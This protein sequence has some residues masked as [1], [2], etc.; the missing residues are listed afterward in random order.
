MSFAVYDQKP[1]L[2]RYRN[3]TPTVITP[4]YASVL[5]S[6]SALVAHTP[7][8]VAIRYFDGTLSYRELDNAASALATTLLGKGFVRGDRLGLFMQNNPAFIIGLL[9]AW[10]LGGTAVTINPMNKAAELRYIFSDSGA[11]ALLCLD[12]LYADAVAPAI[13]QSNGMPGIVVTFSARDGQSMNDARVLGSEP[14][15]PAP[16]GVLDLQEIIRPGEGASAQNAALPSAYPEAG[17]VAL[18]TYTSGTTGKPK[19]AMNTHGNLVFNACV[20]RDWTGLQAGEGNI[21]MAPVFHITGMVAHAATS[22]L[23]GSPLILNHRFHPEVFLEA[24]RRERPIFTIGAITAF[25]SLMNT[26]MIRPGDFDSFRAIYSGGAP[27]SPAIADAFEALTGHYIHNAYGMT[28]TASATLIV[29]QGSRA[30]VD[31]S[32]GALSIGVP[33]FN[34]VIRVVREDGS[35]TQPNEV[36]ELMACGPQLMKGYWN[37]PKETA[38]AVENGFLHTGDVGFMDEAGWFYLVDR[39]KDMINAGGYKVWPR[40]VEDV[41]YGHP[42]IREVA[43][44]GIPDDYRGE[45]IKAIVSLKDGATVTAQ[46]LIAYGKERM[47]A[48]KCPRTIEFM[49]DLP[50]TNTGKILRRNLR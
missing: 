25:I 22:L 18:L 46:D 13:E 48:Y 31:E 1:W 6:F 35:P 28:E 23:V 4:D 14:R 45:T 19:G 40:E 33:V 9:A 39:K 15:L 38:E 37:R 3:G 26:G 17:D 32:S 12:T 30:P 16:D 49:N 43:V 34:T 42:A 41:F 21:C 44:V 47:S 36:G 29:P 20:F 10:K 5:E 50:K 27:V 2:A 24:I 7:N 8:A 11:K